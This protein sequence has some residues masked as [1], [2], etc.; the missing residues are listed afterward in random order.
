MSADFAYT[1]TGVTD[2]D[3]VGQREAPCGVNNNT[4][5]LTKTGTNG[6]QKVSYKK[7]PS[8]YRYVGKT[9]IARDAECL[10]RAA[11][12]KVPMFITNIHS[13]TPESEIVNY[14]RS[15]TQETV[16]LEKIRMKK[17]RGHIAYKFLVSESKLPSYL[18]ENL[19]P[20]GII[21]RRFVHFNRQKSNRSL[22]VDDLQ[23]NNG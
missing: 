1:D 19:W 7:K 5:G 10:F 3:V 4:N 16:S 2:D 9:G 15:K 21:F 12:R 22:F 23:L 11:D 20:R 6:W 8:K 18:D 13:E 17:E 14:I